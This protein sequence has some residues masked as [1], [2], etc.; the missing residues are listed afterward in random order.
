MFIVHT[1]LSS[2]DNVSDWSSPQPAMWKRTHITHM[3]VWVRAEPEAQT[4]LTEEV[5]NRCR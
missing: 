4:G 1:F 3:F 2:A 5:D